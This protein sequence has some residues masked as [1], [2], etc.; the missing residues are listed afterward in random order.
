MC[1]GAALD[2]IWYHFNVLGS[3]QTGEFVPTSPDGSKSDCPATGIK[4]IPKYLTATPTSTSTEGTS[5]PT[6]TPYLGKGYLQA[7]SVGSGKGALIGAGKWYPSSGTPATYTAATS[8][9]FQTP[10]V[11]VSSCSKGFKGSL[12]F[13]GDGFTLTT[14]KGPCDIIA[15]A[16][17]CA[18][19]NTA[20]VFTVI[21][22]ALKSQ[23]THS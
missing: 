2:E 9:T 13:I 22:T 5:T 10:H 3:V 14:S 20:G 11:Y 12:G 17:S 8:G 19:G 21:I 1:S 6:G 16:L 4:Y 7:Y 23:G 15:G 18:T